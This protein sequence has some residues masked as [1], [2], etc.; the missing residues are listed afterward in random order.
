MRS[1]AD[2]IQHPSTDVVSQFWESVIGIEGDW[3]PQDPDLVDWDLAMSDEPRPR[4]VEPIDGSVW[5]TVVKKL[6]SWKAPGRDGICGFWWKHFRQATIFLG[7]AVWEMLEEGDSDNI[8][9]WFVKGRTVLIPK[10]GCEG[11]PEQYRPITCLNTAYKLLTAVM[12]EVLYEHAMAHSYLPLEQRAIRRGH[13][14]CLDALMV[15][16]MFAREAMVRRRNLSVAWI[17]YQKAYDRVPQAWLREMLSIVRAP[18]SIQR[19]LECLRQKWSSV[20]CVGTGANAARMELTYRRG[21]F[22]GDSL[23]P[24]LYC[25]SI[26]PIS[27]AFRKTRGYR[28]LSLDRPVTHQYFMDDLKVYAKSS[29]TLDATL[30]VVDRVSRAVGMELGLRKCAVAHVQQ[31]RYVGGENYLLPE[32]R[33]IE[34]VPQGGAYKYLGTEQLFTA[35]HT[36]VRVRLQQVYA[37]RLYKI[38]SSSL[39][40]KHKVHATNTWTVAVFRYFFPLVKW[41]HNALV[42]LDR[43]TRRI[44][45]RFK[46]H[47]HS[48]SIERLYLSH[49]NGGWGLVNL[50]QAW[51]REVVASELYLVNA[52][53]DELLQAVVQHQLYLTSRDKHSSLQ[54]ACNIL[55]RYGVLTELEEGVWSGESIPMT[56]EGMLQLKATQV[57]K[58]VGSLTAKP[59]HK[60]YYQQ[61]SSADGVDTEGSF[62]WLSDGRLRAETEG[63]VIAAQDGVILTNRYK[64][65]V[66]GMG[67]SPTCRVCGEEDETIGYIVSS[68]KPHMWSLYKER[69]DRVIYQLLKALAKKL[70]VAVPDSIKWGV[71]GRHG[72][73]A[74]EG[75]GAKIAVDLAVPTDRQ[76]S[77]RRPDLILYLKGERKIVIL[78]GAV[79][80]E[81]L[82]AERERQKADKYRKLAA[83]C[84]IIR[85]V[86]CCIRVK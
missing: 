62:A 48:A 20:F 24:L 2:G 34:R 81:P 60:V 47:H 21:V 29:N 3:D 19:M 75:A 7:Q 68:C 56:R 9:A 64:H 38:W 55:R 70:E 1:G 61:A 51:E 59:I 6:N 26:A 74:L 57:V 28:L 15:D 86:N 54:T 5:G 43:L 65:T 40:A 17:D 72:V 46:S 16:S 69:H 27:H 13:R 52:V 84:Q 67:V 58:F 42:Q 32:E 82:L 39:S 36:S 83:G 41:P 78:E 25:L 8:P 12:T 23:S 66:L 18:L 35:D 45:R 14:G 11:R 85:C 77:D 79:T 30:R 71:E 73:A 63:L 37:K 4:V 44:L 10:A 33:T 53:G 76:L 50:Y 49:V 22:Q 31:G 80:W